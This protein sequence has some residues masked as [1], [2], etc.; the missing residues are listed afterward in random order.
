MTS[1]MVSYKVKPEQTA[2]NEELI[3]AVFAEL[4]QVQPVGIRYAVSRLDDGVSFIHLILID[5]DEG[6]NPLPQLE[7]L[8][9]FHAGV[10][11]RCEE[12]PVRTKL[13]EI[14]SFPGVVALQ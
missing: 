13:S 5:G 4:D 3:H 2:R 1:H 7:S 11:E 14:G 10:R 6:K 8:R 12:P 9:A